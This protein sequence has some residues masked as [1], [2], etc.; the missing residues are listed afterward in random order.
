MKVHVDLSRYLVDET[1]LYWKRMP[2]WS[3]ISKEEKWCQ[4]LIKHQKN[5]L[6]LLF[7]VSASDDMKLKILLVYH[8]ENLRALK[9]IAKG[10]LPVMWNRNPK[11]WVIQAIFQDWLFHHL[12][13]EIEKYCL[14]KDISHST[15][16][17]CS[18]VLQATPHSWLTSSYCQRSASATK[19]FVT[20]P[21]CGPGSDSNFQE[22]FTSHFLSGSKGRCWVRNS[23]VTVLKRL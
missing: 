1:G 18:T 4:A 22:V 10:F 20:H 15:F 11:A 2:N 5:R 13:L 21:A 14:E 6:T 17:C 12:I 19:Y 8:S 23:L 3:Y 7:D 16:F 9:N